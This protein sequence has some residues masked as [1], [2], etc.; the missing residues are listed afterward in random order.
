ML[1]T[2][3]EESDTRG[4]FASPRMAQQALDESVAYTTPPQPR[5]AAFPL[6]RRNLATMARLANRARRSP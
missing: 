3:R 6:G 1:F 5:T 2:P 4:I